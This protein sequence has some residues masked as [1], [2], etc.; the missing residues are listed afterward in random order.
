MATVVTT[1]ATPKFVGPVTYIEVDVESATVIYAGTNVCY[2]TGG[3]QYATPASDVA[4]AGDAAANREAAADLYIGVAMDSSAS[5]S[6]DPIRVAIPPTKIY[7][8]QATAAAIE[9]G[10]TLEMFADA[11]NTFDDTHVEGSTSQIAV[12]VKTKSSTVETQVLCRLIR[13]KQMTA[14]EQD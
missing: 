4:D 11:T 14:W 7:L 5:G 9:T 3:T 8:K 1:H 10:D 2:K 13:T 6:T 12:C